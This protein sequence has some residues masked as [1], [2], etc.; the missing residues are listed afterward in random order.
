MGKKG[1]LRGLRG[2]GIL[3]DTLQ[4]PR[5]F[6]WFSRHLSPTWCNHGLGILMETLQNL[7]CSSSFPYI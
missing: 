5:F 6:L 4:K 3:G 1:L 7:G 2:L